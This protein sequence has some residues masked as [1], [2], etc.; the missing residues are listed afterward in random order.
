[1]PKKKSSNQGKG[2]SDRG[3][4]KATGKKAAAKGPQLP[5]EQR[6]PVPISREFPPDQ[7]GVTSNHFVIQQDDSE[8]H[9]LFFQTHPP[10]VLADTDEERREIL[11]NAEARSICV[12]RI[13]VSADR[14]PSFIEA[15]ESNLKRHNARKAADDAQ[16]EM[17]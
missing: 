14:L 16:K 4:K 7:V 5:F 3:P 6:V 9:L 15:M 1:M 2:A 8:F 11:A 13:I 10:V 12:A 17:P